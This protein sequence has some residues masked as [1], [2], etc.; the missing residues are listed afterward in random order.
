MARRER[1]QAWKDSLEKNR[2]LVVYTLAVVGALCAAVGWGLLPDQVS[3]NPE[4]EDIIYRTKGQT[5]GLHAG[6]LALFTLL[7]WRR[8]RQLAYLSGA[9]VS[10]GLTVLMLYAN[11]G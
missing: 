10:L 7:F 8:P 11:L 9:L 6:L 4:V 1:F 5:V 2:N 3:I